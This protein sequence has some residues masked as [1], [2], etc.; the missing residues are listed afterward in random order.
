MIK[1]LTGFFNCM[2]KELLLCLLSTVRSAQPAV[3]VGGMIENP[4]VLQ[5]D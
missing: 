2:R 5:T 3:V 4:L 1:Q